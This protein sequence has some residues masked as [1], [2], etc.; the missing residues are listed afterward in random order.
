MGCAGFMSMSVCHK[1]N[2]PPKSFSLWWFIDLVAKQTCLLTIASNVCSQRR[3]ID[4]ILCSQLKVSNDIS[5]F[6]KWVTLQWLIKHLKSLQCLWCVDKKMCWLL[7]YHQ[8]GTFYFQSWEDGNDITSGGA[9]LSCQNM[10]RQGLDQEVLVR[11]Y[12]PLNWTV[13]KINRFS[14]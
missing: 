5:I 14:L 9:S 3:Q 6:L 2:A 12:R 4:S 13:R 11:Q 7:S 1:I 8:A 10:L